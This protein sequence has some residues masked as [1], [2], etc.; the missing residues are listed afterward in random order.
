MAGV[1][2][3][4]PDGPGPHL[5]KIQATALVAVFQLIIDEAGRR[6]LAGQAPAR[7][8]AA[9]RPVIAAAFDSLDAWLSLPPPVSR[10]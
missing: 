1:I 9:L 2:A 6:L 3:A 4:A 10:G 5:A 7:I 8:A